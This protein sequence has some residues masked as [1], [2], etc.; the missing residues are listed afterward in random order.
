MF[1]PNVI[2]LRTVVDRL[3]DLA[4]KFLFPNTFFF[5]FFSIL[6]NVFLIFIH[7]FWYTINSHDLSEFIIINSNYETHNK[8]MIE[9]C[10]RAQSMLAKTTPHLSITSIAVKN[11]IRALFYKV[12]LL[13]VSPHL[14]RG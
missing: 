3:F 1:Y 8:N 7:F 4:T 14:F 12:F 5:Y 10:Q 2:L 13:N 6:A 11:H 9:S